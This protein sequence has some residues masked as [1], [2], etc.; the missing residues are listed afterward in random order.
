[1]LEHK[2]DDLKAWLYL[3]IPIVLI[4]IFT[5]YPI[6]NTTLIAFDP[7]YNE[8]LQKLSGRFSLANFVDIF[9]YSAFTK[10]L[11]NTIIV[12]FVSVPLSTVVALAIAIGLNSIKPLQKIF[13]T[14]FFLPYV[15]NT[16]AV[17]MVFAVLFST[18]TGLV[19]AIIGAQ[20][21]IEW[22]NVSN[23]DNYFI[24]MLVL[25]IYLLWNNLAFK[26]LVFLGGLQSI[27]KQYYD[28]AKIDGASSMKINLRITLPLLGPQVMFILVTSFIGAFKT[29]DV[30][31]ALFG[32][33]WSMTRNMQT[34][35]GFI[36]WCI[37]S[38]NFAKGA[39][40]SV[41]LLV[42]ILIFTGLQFLVSKRRVHY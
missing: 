7:N 33:N 22:L 1:M 28:A 37:G 36:Y 31:V 42:I 4:G 13:Q 6:V 27:G 25:N 14:I 3:C 17:G 9:N 2:R 29:Y 21:N 12:V 24:N 38:G 35:V 34:I 40:A 8:A 41:V 39:A 5:F 23:T 30:I 18:D 11:L 32:N 20:E 26:V 16:I 10:V 15:T 19:N